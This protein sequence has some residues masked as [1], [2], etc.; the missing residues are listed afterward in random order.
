MDS[1]INTG[2]FS[3]S[4][5][6][7]G[8]VFLARMAASWTG[9]DETFWTYTTPHRPTPGGRGLNSL[10]NTGDTSWI[11]PDSGQA[12]LSGEDASWS[13]FDE[14]FWGSTPAPGRRKGGGGR[15]HNPG[16][17]HDPGRHHIVLPTRG[18][19]PNKNDEILAMTALL[20][21]YYVYD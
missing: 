5:P 3:W 10:I 7:P 12:F 2:D 6:D 8:Q 13:G 19:A 21:V 9:F 1:L 15:H 16:R 20:A 14:T 17:H 4:A 11:A 18:V